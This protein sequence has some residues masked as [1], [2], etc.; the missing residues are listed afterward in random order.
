MYNLAL[1]KQGHLYI[2]E[3]STL[4]GRHLKHSPECAVPI[5]LETL[6]SNSNTKNS[7]NNTQSNNSNNKN[8][9]YKDRIVMTR[10]YWGIVYSDINLYILVW[11]D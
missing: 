8:Y 6:S 7:S 1:L 2:M 10:N 5:S 11:S 4:V 3:T 9:F